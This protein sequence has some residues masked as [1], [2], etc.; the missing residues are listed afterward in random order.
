MAKL[1]G[2][3]NDD[4]II[5]ATAI[6]DTLSG[7]AGDDLIF[8][9]GDAKGGIGLPPPSLDPTGGGA[10]DNDLLNG[11]LGDDTVQAG[12]GNDTLLGGDGIDQLFGDFG[13]DRLDGGAGADIMDGGVGDDL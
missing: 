10:L 3:I 9:Y 13:M 12:N 5:G 8:G 4:T 2:T 1:T 6:S 11:G 7:A